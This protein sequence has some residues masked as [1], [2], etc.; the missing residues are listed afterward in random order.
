M[1]KAADFGCFLVLQT[2]I[3]LFSVLI[4]VG[5]SVRPAFETAL[6]VCRC[7]PSDVQVLLE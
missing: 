3:Y 4:G 7:D 1:A 2:L 6:V 5:L